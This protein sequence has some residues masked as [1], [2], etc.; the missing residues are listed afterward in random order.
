MCR[1]VDV[2]GG[3]HPLPP[4]GAPHLRHGPLQREG[5]PEMAGRDSDGHKKFTPTAPWKFFF[6]EKKPTQ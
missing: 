2:S 1:G 6:A 4:S 3:N 5:A